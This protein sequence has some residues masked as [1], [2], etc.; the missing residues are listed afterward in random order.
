MLE[1]CKTRNSSK[2]RLSVAYKDCYGPF[3]TT[4]SHAEEDLSLNVTCCE[5]PFTWL[6]TRT[7][8]ETGSVLQPQL[9][10]ESNHQDMVRLKK[11]RVR[12]VLLL[13]RANRLHQTSMKPCVI[14]IRFAWGVVD[15]HE[16]VP[17]YSGAVAPEFPFQSKSPTKLRAGT[18]WKLTRGDGH[19]IRCLI[20]RQALIKA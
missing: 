10:N 14:S 9:E 13:S 2:T 12:M 1:A 20:F 4:G 6:L 19:A 18:P 11:P 8:T 16:A 3:R 5:F 7:S 17:I 15:F